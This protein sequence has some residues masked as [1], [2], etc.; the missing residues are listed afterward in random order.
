MALPSLLLRLSA[1]GRVRRAA[2]VWSHAG[3]RRLRCPGSHHHHA[4]RHT[5]DKAAGGGHA[6]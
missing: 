6:G 1:G 4:T 2:P 5:Q 3:G